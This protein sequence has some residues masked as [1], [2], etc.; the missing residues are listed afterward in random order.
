MILIRKGFDGLDISYPLTIGPEVAAKLQEAKAEAERSPSGNGTFLHNGLMMNVAPTGARG[1]YTYRCDSGC[2]GPFGEIWFL[3]Q[4]N[5]RADEWGVRVSCRA[6]PLALEGLA[7]VRE[8]I[9]TT[10]QRLGLAYQPG[11]ES[12]GRVD[13]ACDVLA[14][15]LAPDR[16]HFVAHSRSRVQDISDTITQVDGRSGRVETITIG[17]NPGRQVVLYDK[18]AEI[19]ATR[20]LYWARVWDAELKALGLPPLNLSDRAAS[21]VWRVEVRAHKRHLKDKWG[22]TTWGHLR[23]KLPHILHHALCDVRFTIPQTDS[24]RA[25][26][27]DHPLWTLV[28]DAL[29]DDME[30]LRSMV[31][32]AE[33]AEMAL[34][35][36]DAMLAAQING[37]LLSRA[38]L[39]NVPVD[40]LAAFV[41]GFANQLARD[42]DRQADRTQERLALARARLGVSLRHWS[43]CF[44]R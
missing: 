8:R 39:N 31:D 43:Q 21:E 19:L 24:N 37:C 26:W 38:A 13:V 15:G 1:G 25:R 16:V 33:I 9:E 20:K 44:E 14:P 12:I 18:R 11:T 35:E 28:G 29:S 42:W 34:A 7:K 41:M 17:K 2:G 23:E 3:K 30:G 40:R 36:R 22:V 4:P 6:L 5:G 10:L 27:P 32:P